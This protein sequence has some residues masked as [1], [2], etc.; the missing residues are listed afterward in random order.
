MTQEVFEKLFSERNFNPPPPEAEFGEEFDE[1]LEMLRRVL[2]AHAQPEEFYLYEA[3]NQARFLDVAFESDGYLEKPLVEDVQRWLGTMK[4][5]W[6]V[7]LWCGCFLLI[8]RNEI[9]GFDPTHE[10][11]G[12]SKLVEQIN[13][14]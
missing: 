9:L 7:S 2:L 8:T 10:V 6:M 3:H 13:G 14:A 12:F 4:Q 5:D 1:A 11:P